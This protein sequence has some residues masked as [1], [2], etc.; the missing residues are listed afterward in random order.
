MFRSRKFGGFPEAAIEAGGNELVVHVAYGGTRC[1]PRGRIALTTLGGDPEFGERA[2]NAQLRGCVVNELL[3]FAGSRRDRR[4]VAV[5]LDRES[6]SRFAGCGDARDY[7]LSP[8]RFD[9]DDNTSRHV[10]VGSGSDH[11]PEVQ[12]Q[13]SAELQAAVSVWQSN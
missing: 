3:R 5:A 10:W 6:G 13:I 8:C 9:T 12:I 11:R 1:E 4:D 2:L 7:A